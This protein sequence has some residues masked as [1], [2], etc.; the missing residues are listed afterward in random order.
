MVKRGERERANI[1]ALAA[2][3]AAAADWLPR[4]CSSDAKAKQSRAEQEQADGSGRGTG[5]AS[6]DAGDA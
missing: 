2:V 6:L 1:S 3:V 4:K 5:D